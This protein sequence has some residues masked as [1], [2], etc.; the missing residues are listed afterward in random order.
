MDGSRTG[1]KSPAVDDVEACLGSVE[2][3]RYHAPSGK[4]YG[5]KSIVTKTAEIVLA[6]QPK[7]KRVKE[8]IA[9][10]EKEMAAAYPESA[11]SNWFVDNLMNSVGRL[12]GRKIDVG[13]A[14]FGGI[15]AQMPAGNVIL[16]DLLSMFPF[17]NN[18]VYVQHKGS[19][20]RKMLEKMASSRFQVLGGVRVVSEGGRLVSAEIGGE[21]IDDDRLYGVATISFLLNGGDNLH[22]AA[23]AQELIVFDEYVID[24]ILYNVRADAAAGRPLTGEADGRVTIL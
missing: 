21:P 5:R 3:G 14:N 24:A 9:F 7:M 10:S 18:V 6:A 8:V 2:K 23:N 16:D 1:C 22:L 15:R 17:R 4:L 11:L 19:E 20:I 13:V 12:S